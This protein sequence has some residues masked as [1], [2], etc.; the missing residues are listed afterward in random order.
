MR[1][2]M[3]NACYW[4]EW[5]IEFENLCKK[6]K[7]KCTCESR[8]FVKVETKF[9]NDLIWIIW[10]C[11][12]HYG[13]KKNN[14]FI[15]ELLQSLYSLF[16]IKYTT[17]SCKKR[18]YLLYFAV[19]ILTENIS[20]NIELINNKNAINLFK[21]KINSIYKQ[22]KKNEKSPN[23]EYLFANIEKENTFEKS[24]KKMQILNNID[25]QNRNR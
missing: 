8:S 13:N 18:R 15:N 25:G 19:S 6:R 17:A 9:R 23:T 11:I 10:D 14:N 1:K 4:I 21:N 20:S 12:L 16:C 2:N 22:I 3:L 7:N 5:T 24:L